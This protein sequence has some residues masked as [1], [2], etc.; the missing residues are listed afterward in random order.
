M[1]DTVTVYWGFD[2]IH[3]NV[4]QYKFEQPSRIKLD[5]DNIASNRNSVFAKCP[6]YQNVLNNTFCI[7]SKFDF[8]L[9]IENGKT[10]VKHPYTNDNFV[11]EFTTTRAIEVK[12]FGIIC[13]YIFYCDEPLD[14]TL[15]GAHFNQNEFINN[16]MVLPG[17]FNIN[18]WVRP[19]EIAFFMKNNV[20]EV[21]I[22]D[23][24][25]LAYVNF[26]TSKKIIFK[27]F[28]ITE[29]INNTIREFIRLRAYSKDFHNLEYFYNY[30]KINKMNKYI[31]NMIKENLVDN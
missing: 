27:R 6:A 29:D 31:K 21:K 5:I 17:E 9:G 7:K 24:D 25:V 19:I 4:S 3:K 11:T 12:L 15:T 14:M 22:N 16:T 26:N 8:T 13:P 18:N 10:V 2:A 1:S 20:S 23:N 28:R 30:F